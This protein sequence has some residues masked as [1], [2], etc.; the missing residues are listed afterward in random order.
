MKLAILFYSAS[1]CEK[2]VEQESFVEYIQ[3]PK[4]L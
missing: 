3:M 2:H 4:K 1:E